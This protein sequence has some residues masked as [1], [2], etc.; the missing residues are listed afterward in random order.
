[1]L[2]KAKIFNSLLATAALSR[3]FLTAPPASTSTAVS[4]H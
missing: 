2:P 3:I 1:M 4:H